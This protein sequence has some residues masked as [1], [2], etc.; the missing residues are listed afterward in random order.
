MPGPGAGTN[1]RSNITHAQERTE[2]GTLHDEV[3]SEEG[4]FGTT[5]RVQVTAAR[6]D[7][8]ICTGEH[9]VDTCTGDHAE[10]GTCTHENAEVEDAED[11][12]DTDS[13]TESIDGPGQGL[14]SPSALFMRQ[15]LPESA[16]EPDEATQTCRQCSRRFTLFVRRHHCRRCG[17]LFCDTCS[18][19]RALL[20]L[21]T[22]AD[23]SGNINT[24]DDD[25]P[26]ARLVGAR[27]THWRFRDH[28]VCDPCCQTV[29]RLP[30]AYPDSV[31]LVVAELG[32]SDA[33][34]NAYNIFRTS[35]QPTVQP[36]R[37][38]STS[39]VRICPVCDRD[40][41]TV[42]A[43]MERVPG[44]GWQEAQERHIRG[45]IEDTSANMQGARAEPTRSRSI[46]SRPHMSASPMSAS[47]PRH[48]FLTLFDRSHPEP[49]AHSM[50]D[51]P[52]H[53]MAR[54]PMGVKYVAYKLNS[55][56]PLLGQECAICFD[57]FEPGQQVARLNCLC[58]YHLP[59][60]SDWLLRTPACPVHYE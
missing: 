1:M 11:N 23:Q 18:A 30:A 56:T 20:A 9:G 42:W 49:F 55:D 6:D 51:E 15:C 44:E 26:L 27:S 19:Q 58:T 50:A 25:T 43:H 41:A 53:R 40:W 12:V 10:V 32:S 59:C 3:Q 39:S 52:A 24:H 4:E 17:L 60:I 36:V 22:R 2:W 33:A 48:T 46:Q 34:E 8:S 5:E 47:Q 29:A 13:D 7:T 54:S 14:Y 31:A 37:R 28:R 35:A 16:W 45:C 57:D 21:P 38:S